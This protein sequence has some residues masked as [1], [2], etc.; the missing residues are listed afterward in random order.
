MKKK[1]N[2]I[3]SNQ[4]NANAQLVGEVVCNAKGK[5]VCRHAKSNQQG[6]GAG[7]CTKMQEITL[8]CRRA[9]ERKHKA[10]KCIKTQACK[11]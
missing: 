8:V 10:E 11:A 4:L 7:T 9:C 6:T 5:S 2:Q 1:T 3:K